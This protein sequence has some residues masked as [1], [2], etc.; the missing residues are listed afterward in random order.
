MKLH[1]RK[2]TAPQTDETCPVSLPRVLAES[3]LL[4][5]LDYELTRAGRYERA[6]S[7]LRIVPH[8]PPGEVPS[9]PELAAVYDCVRSLVREIDHVGLLGDSSLVAILPETDEDAARV[10]AMRVASELTLR[11]AARSQRNWLVGTASVRTDCEGA[12]A[13]LVA[14]FHH[15]V[16]HRGRAA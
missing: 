10:V 4:R 15:A 5:L 1:F 7:L 2:A 6:L 11:R 8:L 14:A 16:R 3:E 12:D 9:A 13:L